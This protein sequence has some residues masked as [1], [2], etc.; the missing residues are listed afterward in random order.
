MFHTPKRTSLR[1]GY[2]TEVGRVRDHNEDNLSWFDPGDDA[3][4]LS[5]KGWLCIVADGMGGHAAG[6]VAS[7]VAVEGIVQKYQQSQLS[8]PSALQEAIQV[9][10]EEIF[11]HNRTGV[12]SGMGTTVV[13]AVIRGD[14]L[15][16]AHVGDSRA[17][18]LR[19]KSLT[20]LTRD[21]TLVNDLLRAN[22]I[23]PEE[24]KEHPQ[25]HVISRAL[26]KKIRTDPE[27]QDPIRLHNGDVLLLCTDGISGYL[28]DEQIA[29]DLESNSSDPQLAATALTQHADGIGGEDNATAIVVFIDKAVPIR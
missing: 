7:K 26:G 17:Y 20:L 21:H 9:T 5:R 23:T 19:Q 14:E 15:I 2:R 16:I 27:M 8:I 6:E 11:Q 24:A 10:N 4:N 13:T 12:Q 29:Y 3:D 1:L 25:R 22:A 18:L 28:S